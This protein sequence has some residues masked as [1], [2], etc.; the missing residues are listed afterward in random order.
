[1][2]K[3]LLSSRRNLII[4]LLLGSLFVSFGFVD[5][6]FEIAKNLDTFASLYRQL[7][8]QYVAEVNPTDLMREGIEGMLSSLDPYTEF[9]PESDIEDFRTNYVSKQAICG[10]WGQY[11]Y[12]CCRQSSGIGI[13]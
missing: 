8:N 10:N 6:Y 7:N 1:M 4:L 9:A 13:L 5:R 12:Q 11:F 2:K 3:Y